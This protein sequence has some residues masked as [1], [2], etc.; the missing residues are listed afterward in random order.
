VIEIFPSHVPM[1]A[2]IRSEILDPIE[3]DP[4]PDRARDEAYLNRVCRR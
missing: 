3:R 1:R 2:K 4:D